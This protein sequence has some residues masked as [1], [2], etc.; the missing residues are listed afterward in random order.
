MC[1]QDDPLKI[2][3]TPFET[4]SVEVVIDH[5]SFDSVSEGI[6]EGPT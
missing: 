4:A 5:V 6:V 3:N 1:T 2:A